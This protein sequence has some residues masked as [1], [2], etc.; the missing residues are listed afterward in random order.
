MAVLFVLV[1]LAVGGGL[2]VLAIEYG[3]LLPAFKSLRKHDESFGKP[4]MLVKIEC[5]GPV[6][7]LLG[8]VVMIMEASTGRSVSTTPLL[9]WIGILMLAI[10]QIGLIAGLFKLRRK[11]D[12]SRFSIAA[13]MFIL[14]LLLSLAL[15]PL[16]VIAGLA[17]W[18]LTSLATSAALKKKGSQTVS[19]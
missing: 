6:V 11:H 12:D 15:S 10:G 14:N 19:I 18:I 1:L 2:M 16:A 17:G 13:I 7:L 5:I 9:F 3:H 8:L 4:L